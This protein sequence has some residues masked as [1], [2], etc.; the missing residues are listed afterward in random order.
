[1][2]EQP[3]HPHAPGTRVQVRNR[4]DGSWVSGF[5]VA[6]AGNEQ[7]SYGVRRRSDRVVLPSRFDPGDVR[8][9]REDAGR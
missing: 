5:E 2:P 6:D 4:F 7:T 9:E 1:M 3:W 8:P